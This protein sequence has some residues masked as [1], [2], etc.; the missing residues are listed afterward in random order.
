MP[1]QKLQFKPGVNRDQT[2]Y[3]N[4]GGWYECD[5][6]RFR[7]GMPEKIGGW[8][9]ATPRTI[10]GTCR[11][12]FGW[13]TSYADNFLALGTN[14]K[15]YIEVG[16]YFY[17]ITPVRETTAAG[18]VTFTATNGSST[19][20]VLD[21]A[22]GSSAGDYV[23]LSGA[24][25][26]GG[27]ITAAVLNQNY[28][29]VTAINNDAYT[30]T[31]KSPTTG[32]AVLANA[33][34]SGTG[35]NATVGAY[36]IAVGAAGG[37]YGYGFGTGTWNDNYGWGLASPDPVFIE[38]QDWWFDQ[39]DNDLVM[40]IRNGP[41]YYWERGSLSVPETSLATPATALSALTLNGV[42]P[43]SVPNRVMQT[44]VSQNDKHLLAFGCQPYAGSA[45]D[46]DPLLIRWA[47]QDQ[48]NVWNPLV[49]NTAGFLRVA[50]G[51]QIVRAIPTKQEIL[52][53]T[54]ATLNSLQFLGT[55][56]VFSLQEIGDNLSIMGPR[57]VIIVNNMTFWMGHDKF[58]VYTGR[59][60]TLPCTLRN[61]VFNDINFDQAPQIIAGT[62]EGWNEVWWMYPSANSNY[63]DKYVIY[64]HLERLWYYGNIE[65][66]AWLDSPLR[67]YPQAVYTDN[68]TQIGYLIDHE[69]GTNDDT[70][71][72]TA[73]IQSSDFDIAD[74]D[75][76]MLTRRIIPDLNFEGSTAT[77]PEAS[78]IIRPRNF[79]GSAYQTNASN[80]QRVI[81]TTVDQFTD[82]VFVRARARQLALKVQSTG[83]DTQWQLGSPRL[84]G[85]PDGRR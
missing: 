34:D 77:S 46:F 81:E 9:K 24:V 44:L 74:G 60:E 63:N 55:N 73:Y 41:V 80:T 11:Q 78:F 68:T 10:L 53:F 1:F 2:N 71:A 83:L 75:Q 26:L 66:T 8:L 4:E 23:T 30:I 61:H 79:P 62:N 56:D 6:I 16:G 51:S 82:Q 20:T 35:G 7:S 76:F 58:Y 5:K 84:D 15:A 17:D 85:R 14:K 31:A 21:T 48:P 47:T 59:V 57:A 49:T 38:Q 32:V 29:I 65:R 13:I 39:F 36:Q 3:T 40:N 33:S 69:R 28:E 45:T 52:V 27:N 25:S 19:I 64:N 18:D 67:E 50:R 72:M 43:Q 37:T 22:F 42:A 54:E 12:M 70:V